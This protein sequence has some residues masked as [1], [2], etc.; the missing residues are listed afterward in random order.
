[1]GSRFDCSDNED[2]S[3]DIIEAYKKSGAVKGF[4]KHN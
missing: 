1:V 3:K 4:F 2:L